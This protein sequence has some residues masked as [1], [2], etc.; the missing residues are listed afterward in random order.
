MALTSGEGNKASRKT[1]K[2][3]EPRFWMDTKDKIHF[4][5]PSRTQNIQGHKSQV[6]D[7]KNHTNTVTFVVRG[8]PMALPRHRSTTK[9]FT[10]N[11]S[12]PQQELFKSIARSILFPPIEKNNTKQS[13]NT[14]IRHKSASIIDDELN[15][16]NSTVFG[17]EQYIS[18][19]LLFRQRRPKA[20]FVGN[21]PTRG[22]RP[23]S[24]EKYRIT[25]TDVD[26][27]AKF[28]MD[29]LN[30]ILYVDDKQVVELIAKKVLD[31]EG[32]CLGATEITASLINE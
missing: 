11:P 13:D 24:P 1:K 7:S 15:M 32:Q 28:V 10:Y 26:N 12:K 16:Q 29:S 31:S 5:L 21:D 22:L 14:I 27:L 30:G 20:H 17:E 4:V 9:G 19:S 18:L 25:R 2:K 3:S 8:D 6:I 23:T